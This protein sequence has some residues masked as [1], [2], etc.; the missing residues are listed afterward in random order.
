ML[1]ENPL[2][3]DIDV[4]H[5][6]NLQT[7]LLE[8][9][10]TKR[11]IILI[12]E[13][14]K[15]LK[16]VHSQRAQIVRNIDRV[17]QPR[18]VAEKVYKANSDVADFVAV[19]ER[20]AFDR[21]FGQVQDTWRSDE[22]LDVYVHRMYAML[23][24]YPEG[25]VTYPGSART[26]LGLQWRL[27]ASYEEIK[28]VIERIPASSTAVLGVFDGGALWATLVLGFDSERRAKVVTTVD[29]SELQP[30][31]T[32]KDIAKNVVAW[33]NRKYPPCSLGLFMGLDSARAFLAA[34][35]KTK[36]M[37]E[38]VSKNDLIADPV[39]AGLEKVFVTA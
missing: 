3:A 33:T 30:A 9:A 26:T 2:M 24:D 13:N 19:F 10:K 28:A 14:G 7:L 36:A 17:D 31:A 21:Y 29:P 27:G 4:N 39:P 12:H 8:S 11:R 23:D 37:R 32:R 16:F 1:H 25:I 18:V 35:H 20:R 38:I 5:W 34:T 22:D 6:R 15:V